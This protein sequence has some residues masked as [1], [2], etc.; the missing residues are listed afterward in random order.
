MKFTFLPKMDSKSRISS[1]DRRRLEKVYMH[2]LPSVF[3]REN[4]SK[5]TQ[6][7]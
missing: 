4:L 7:I 1:C 6:V 3:Y 2:I 5:I